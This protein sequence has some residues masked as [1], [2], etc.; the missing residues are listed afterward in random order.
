[1]KKSITWKISINLTLDSLETIMF[2]KGGMFK[3]EISENLLNYIKDHENDVDDDDDDM[4]KTPI[5]KIYEITVQMD[6]NEKGRFDFI[7]GEAKRHKES[8]NETE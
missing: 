6:R 5:K 3:Y 8:L 2:N 7:V 1:M 4:N